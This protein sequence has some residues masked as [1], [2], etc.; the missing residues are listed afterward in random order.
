MVDAK[1]K[2]KPTVKT[3]EPKKIT[4]GTF[5]NLRQL[6]HPV[7]ELL[8]LTPDPFANQTRSPAEPVSDLNPPPVHREPVH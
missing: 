3:R 5:D 2:Q 8:G 4:H 7:E 1:E 6:P